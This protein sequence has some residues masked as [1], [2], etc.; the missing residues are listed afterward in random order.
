MAIMVHLNDEAEH[1]LRERAAAQGRSPEDLV[2]EAVA[3]SLASQDD[4]RGDFSARQRVEEWLKWTANLPRDGE[5]IDD[6]R[7]S[8]YAGRGE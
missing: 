7:D 2:N 5:A 6:S 8:I 4:G 3:E 1:R